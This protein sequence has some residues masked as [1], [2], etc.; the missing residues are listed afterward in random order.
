MTATSGRQPQ[1][2]ACQLTAQCIPMW[3]ALKDAGYT[4]SYWSPL[5]PIP[6]LYTS[7]AGTV[8]IAAYNNAP[9]AG[10]TAMQNAMDAVVPDTQ[11]TSYAN[12]QAYFATAVCS[13]LRFEPGRQNDR[14]SHRRTSA[15]CCP[16]SCGVFPAWSGQSA[17][18]PHRWPPLQTATSCCSTAVDPSSRHTRT[19][20]ATSYSRSHRRPKRRAGLTKMPVAVRLPQRRQM[21]GPLHGG[22]APARCTCHR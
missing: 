7:M 1:A 16:R 20:A 13:L 22:P 12:V 18:R 21:I 4:G 11:L 19:L 5:G 9:N 14:R 6:A 3:S 2:I 8:T 17:I 10:L 15:R